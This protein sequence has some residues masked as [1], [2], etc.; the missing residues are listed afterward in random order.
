MKKFKRIFMFLLISIFGWVVLP[1]Q[2]SSI[3]V[4]RTSD[5]F[6][7]LERYEK[8]DHIR[9]Y[10]SADQA[11]VKKILIENKLDFDLNMQSCIYLVY[12]QEGVVK[13]VCVFDVATFYIYRLVV[14]KNFQHK[15]IGK[16]LLY[17]V[18]HLLHEDYDETTMSLHSEKEA[19]GFYKKLGFVFSHGGLLCSLKF[20]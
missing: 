16:A 20:A 2:E 4:K 7:K 14:G 9:Y 13:G 8:N 17:E 15:G 18:M 10:D 5:A 1:C 11:Q 6:L 3:R 12:E 19:I